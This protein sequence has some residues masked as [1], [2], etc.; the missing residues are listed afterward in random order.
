MAIFVLLGESEARRIYSVD[1]NHEIIPSM[2]A[3]LAIKDRAVAECKKATG[4]DG[5][6]I[7][8]NDSA[9][10]IMTKALF[11][12]EIICLDFNK[13]RRLKDPKIQP[14]ENAKLP[15]KFKALLLRAYIKRLD[16]EPY[17]YNATRL[18]DREL[19]SRIF[20]YKQELT[21]WI[22][23]VFTESAESS[24]DIVWLKV[25]NRHE[26][27]LE[28]IFNNIDRAIGDFLLKI[29]EL[30]KLQ[31]EADEASFK[32]N[33]SVDLQKLKTEEE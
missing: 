21:K 24:N 22:E 6:A 14:V 29:D 28:K 10:N 23:T 16:T 7:Y 3:L 12:S 4:I 19:A 1:D 11:R 32:D 9:L 31:N 5:E 17:L 8:I 26:N 33:D 30:E 27:D 18:G 25:V 20:A 13:R 2:E 15:P